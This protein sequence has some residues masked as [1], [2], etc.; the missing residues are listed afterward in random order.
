MV[1]AIRYSLKEEVEQ[2]NLVEIAL[3][4]VKVITTKEKAGK[5]KK[6]SIENFEVMFR[7]TRYSGEGPGMQIVLNESF[8]SLSLEQKQG[9][10]DIFEGLRNEYPNDVILTITTPPNEP[11]PLSFR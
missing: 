9:L 5:I 8:F 2:L 3:D 11:L 1:E 4:N 10:Q 7:T 6:I